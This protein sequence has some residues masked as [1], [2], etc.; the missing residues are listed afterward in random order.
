[1]PVPSSFALNHVPEKWY[2]DAECIRCAYCGKGCA[3]PQGNDEEHRLASI[4]SLEYRVRSEMS[5]VDVPK[6]D[7]KVLKISNSAPES[8]GKGKGVK[9]KRGAPDVVLAS[10]LLRTLLRISGE[11]E[12]ADMQ[13]PIRHAL[14][15]LGFL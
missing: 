15:Y 8:R 11:Q 4:R 13:L 3:L 12:L 10:C 5:L 1:M 6:R 14:R 7:A 2:F 9:L